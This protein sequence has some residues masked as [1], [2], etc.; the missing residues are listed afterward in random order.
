LSQVIQIRKKGGLDSI[1]IDKAGHRIKPDLYYQKY[2]DPNSDGIPMGEYREG[3]IL[4]AKQF[5]APH[6]NPRKK[7]W[8]WGGDGKRLAFLIDKIKLKYEN[9]HPAEGQFIKPGKDMEDHLTDFYDPVFRHSS[10]YGIQYMQDSRG[11]F[12]FADPRQEFMYWIYK[13]HEG[14][15]DRSETKVTSK[16]SP[17]I[18]YELISPAQ[19]SKEKVKSTLREVEA[20]KFV[21]VLYGDDS[22]IRAIC[23]AMDLPTYRESVDTESAWLMLSDASENTERVSRYNGKTH[24]DMFLECCKMPNEDLDLL[25]KV[26]VA[27]KRGHMRKWTDYYTFDGDKIH[28]KNN[29]QLVAYFKDPKNQETLIKLMHLLDENKEK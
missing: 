18:R 7:R 13:G 3:M 25:R 19:E 24:Q 28:V 15:Q 10:F 12:D 9:G 2:K 21:G 14:T 27:N 16:Y 5:M 11:K 17:G 8:D 26:I 22:K 23:E 1:Q 6:W 4:D 20:K 29:V